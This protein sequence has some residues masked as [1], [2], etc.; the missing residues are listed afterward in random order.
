MWLW[1]FEGC[2]RSGTHK[3]ARIVTHALG[4]VV[5]EH[6]SALTLAHSLRERG[7]H[8]LAVLVAYDEAVDNHIDGVYLVS[9]EL[10]TGR[11]LAYLAI[12]TS[13]DISL[14][15]HCLEELAVV[16]LTTLNHWSKKGNTT[17]IK[18]LNHKVAYLLIAI[19]HHSFAR[20]W[21]VGT[22]STCIEKS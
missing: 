8:T 18:A 13:I 9:I 15:R 20:I 1:L 12:D 14:A 10:H 3:V 17:A 22:R 11:H 2:A 4:S 19:S 21:R 6:H 16:A 7:H 5:V